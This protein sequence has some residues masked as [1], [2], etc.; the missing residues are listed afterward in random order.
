[1]KKTTVREYDKEGLLV[2]ET[3]TEESEKEY[4]FQPLYPSYPTTYPM[5]PWQS[6]TIA[7]TVFKHEITCDSSQKG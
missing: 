5:Y 6:P 1:M 7:P 2:K 3:I 4:I